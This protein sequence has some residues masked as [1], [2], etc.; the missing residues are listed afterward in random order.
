MIYRKLGRTDISVSVVA[1][2]CW[3][4]VGDKTWGP[5][6]EAE[7]IATIEAALEAGI[8]FF[9]TAEGYGN[10]Y[11]ESLLGK[12]LSGVRDKV[13]IAS[14]PL[15][16]KA[17][18]PALKQACE[19]ALQRLKTDY[20]DLYQIHWPNRDVPFE[21]TCT[22]LNELHQ[23]GK[24]RAAG[25]SNFGV[26]DLA[27]YLENCSCVSN[28]LPYNLLW[29]VIEAEVQPLCLQH[30]ISI[31]CYSPLAQ[32]LLTGKFSSA[33]Q[34]PEGRARTRHFSKERAQAAHGEEGQEDET[35][36]ALSRIRRIGEEAGHGM[37]ELSLAWLIHRPGVATVLAGSRRPEQITQCAGAAD[38]VLGEA[39]VQSLDRATD[40]LRQA[41]GHNPDM[42][43]ARSRFR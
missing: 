15:S 7:S 5:Q 21:E 20:I 23:E 29:R 38:I 17:T 22:G 14:K 42:W 35:F 12:A 27:D 4:I 1:M 39:T 3:S 13:I 10:G 31:L 2:G 33:E 11:S 18:K 30:D 40:T 6:D 19:Q 37:A 16:S 9:D 41:F 34:V 8:N 24:I 28:Q 36:A 32:A 26:Q 25:I 43:Q